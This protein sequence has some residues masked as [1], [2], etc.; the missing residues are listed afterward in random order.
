MSLRLTFYIPA[1]LKDSPEIAEARELL[2]RVKERYR[3]VVKEE[4]INS[5]E[6]G[7]VK[8]QFLW[9]L[10]VTKR[11]G[12]SQ[13]IRTKSLYPQLVIFDEETPF[14]F[15]PQAYGSERI[16]I[17]D[18]LRGLAD[19]KVKCLHERHIMEEL[20]TKAKK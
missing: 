18:F 2:G 9:R 4:T 10:S 6:E 14:S 12:I 16:S 11:I 17:Q 15:Y 5:Q 19:F 7:Q 20:F 1:R 8:A 3:I 13:T